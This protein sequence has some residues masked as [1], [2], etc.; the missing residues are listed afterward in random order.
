MIQIISIKLN[1]LK[2]KNRKLFKSIIFMILQV[3]ILTKIIFDDIIEIKK[4][5][6]QEEE[7][8]VNDEKKSDSD[9]ND[10]DN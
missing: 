2:S 4:E 7:E 6:N 10:R 8:K 3:R 9:D 5:E 1:E